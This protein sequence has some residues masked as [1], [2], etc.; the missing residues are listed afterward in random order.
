MAFTPQNFKP[1]QTPPI[2]SVWLNGIDVTCNFVL[3]GAQ[4]VPQALAALG[5]GNA[6]ALPILITQGGT[7]ATD[8]A[9]ALT[10]LGGTT[11]AAAVAAAVPVA[12]AAAQVAINPSPVATPAE[13]AAGFTTG[14]L[15]VQYG[16]GNLLRY[17]ADPTGILDSSPAMVGAL[18]SSSVVYG[19]QGTYKFSVT[20]SVGTNQMIIGDGWNTIFQWANGGMTNFLCSGITGARFTNFQVNI[21]PPTTG[22]STYGCVQLLNSSNCTVDRCLFNG[23]VWSGVWLNGAA[24]HNTIYNNWFSG[25]QE[26]ILNGLQAGTGG[27]VSIYSGNGGGTAAPSY[28]V[29]V[30]NDFY[31]GGGYGVQILDE[32]ATVGSGLPFRNLVQGNRIGAHTTYGL[33]LYLPGAGSGSVDTFNRFYDNQVE[34]II[35]ARGLDGVISDP[36]QTT[37]AGIY[38]VGAGIGGTQVHGNTVQNCCINTRTRTLVPAGIGA[39]GV[40]TGL[41]PVSIIGNTVSRMSQGDGI[42]V[43]GGPTSGLGGYTVIGNSVTMP[44]SNN[45]TQVGGALMAGSG[46]SVISGAGGLNNVLLA[47]NNVVHYGT[48]AALFTSATSGNLQNLTLTGGNYTIDIT[49]TGIAWQA[50]Q[51]GGFNITNVNASGTRFKQVVASGTAACANLNA[52]IT[53]CFSGVIFT[54]N[55][56][57]GLLLNGCTGVNITGGEIL[58]PTTCFQS[59]GTCTGSFIDKTVEMNLTTG[60]SAS[61]INNAGTGC[62]IEQNFSSVPTAGTWTIGDRAIHLGVTPATAKGWARVTSSS[63]NI[64][65]TDWISE[66]NL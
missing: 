31:G 37:G 54:S 51:V 52:I 17:G 58:G 49:G 29:I 48:G 3:N 21:L 15:H 14:T 36:A 61:L 56:N 57:V 25:A 24:N 11:Q 39:G 46:I 41:V 26:K 2:K 13:I 33:L 18:A 45:G 23:F 34:N 64:L 63:S 16:V 5:L 65:G 50:A 7:S 59:S 60:A 44:S 12:V 62:N 38:L 27:D 55:L 28:N 66:G 19:P 40:A 8:A 4:T 43:S 47:D 6:G 32:F 9:T 10:N 42:Q 20:F 35:G 22:T 30:N 53:A 1:F